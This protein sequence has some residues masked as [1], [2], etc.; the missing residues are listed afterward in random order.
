MATYLRHWLPLVGRGWPTPPARR[1]PAAPGHAGIPALARFRH[2]WIPNYDRKPTAAAVRK[3]TGAD[4]APYVKARVGHGNTPT[5]K[6]VVDWID[7]GEAKLSS[8]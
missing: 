6:G 1:S 3:M 4:L 8:R 2:E 7:Y 5:I